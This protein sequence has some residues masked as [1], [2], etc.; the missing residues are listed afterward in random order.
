M[1]SS[2]LKVMQDWRLLAPVPAILP[3]EFGY[4][5][6]LTDSPTPEELLASG[7]VPNFTIRAVPIFFMAI[8]LELLVGLMR[9][10]KLYRLN[11]FITSILLGA[12][13]LVTQIWTKMLTLY[14]YCYIYKTFKFHSFPVDSWGTWGGLFLGIDLG[15][16]WMHRTAHTY[17][18]LWSAHSVHHSGEDYN[19]ATALRQGA[20]QG[21]T[22][23]V[24]YLPLALFFHPGCYLGHSALNTLGQFWIHTKVIGDCGPLEYFLNTPSH[25][26]VHHRPPGN[27][28]YGALLIVW[29]RMFGTFR[30][31]KEQKEYYGL[32]RQYDTFDP[33]WA[34]FEHIKRVLTQVKG[35]DS[36]CLKLLKRRARHP[37]VFQPLEVFAPFPKRTGSANNIPTVQ[38]RKKYDPAL[39][40]QIIGVY[41]FSQFVVTMLAMLAIILNKDFFSKYEMAALSLLL[42]L[43]MSSIG[44]ILDGETSVFYVA[45]ETGR[46]ISICYLVLFY[47]QFGGGVESS[48][49]GMKGCTVLLSTWLLTL[50]VGF[51]TKATVDEKKDA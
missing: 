17:H 37:L 9:N 41:A 2:A 31:E 6:N 18:L 32:A 51:G 4:A 27:A 49:N 29:D 16:Y 5:D 40:H 7:A 21:A 36:S 48:G 25:H 28:N 38:K 50:I 33:V 8:G 23:W 11:D 1:A 39:N 12:T 44:R 47:F 43:S 34:N 30:R 26:R 15:Y 45:L 22:S 24:F 20:L 35:S 46:L 13:M 42:V 19:L 14:A 3:K 10:R